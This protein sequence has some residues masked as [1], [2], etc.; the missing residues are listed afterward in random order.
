MGRGG[1]WVWALALASCAPAQDLSAIL[2]RIEKLEA[3]N[4]ELKEQVKALQERVDGAGHPERTGGC[5][6][7]AGSYCTS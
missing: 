6:T 3:E 7:G 2:Q 5:S 4:R 1:R